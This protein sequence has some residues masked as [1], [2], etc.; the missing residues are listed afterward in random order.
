[1]SLLFALALATAAHAEANCS[2][3][4]PG[5][6]PFT[7]D[8]VAAVDHYTDIAPDVRAV[9]KER[10][11]AHHSDEIVTIH[12]DS[13]SGKHEYDPQIRDMHFGAATVCGTVSRAQ[14]QPRKVERALVYCEQGECIIVPAICGNV[15]RVTRLPDKIAE[16]AAPPPPTPVIPVSPQQMASLVHMAA[17]P[18]PEDTDIKPVATPVVVARVLYSPPTMLP[19]PPVVISSR[20]PVRAVPEPG[21]WAMLLA[22]LGFVGFAARRRRGN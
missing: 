12:R 6:N 14:W 3:D 7:G 17:D 2:W 16:A 19:A 20:I 22:G 1:M 8:P 15:S 13:I 11:A 10:I 5:G 18:I 4:H 21:T 9:L